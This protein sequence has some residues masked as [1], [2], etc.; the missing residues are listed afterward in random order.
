M[1]LEMNKESVIMKSVLRDREGFKD[2][3]YDRYLDADQLRQVLREADPTVDMDVDISEAAGL[4]QTETKTH[5][6][7]SAIDARVVTNDTKDGNNIGIGDND[8]DN[9]DDDESLS[10]G[11][12]NDGLLLAGDAAV[13]AD[14]DGAT[15]AGSQDGGDMGDLLYAHLLQVEA[16]SAYYLHPLDHHYHRHRHHH[17]PPHHHHHYNIIII[18]IISS[19][20]L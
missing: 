5:T 13:V 14:G 12:S 6:E 2:R 8:D 9:D 18:T 10:F 1:H 19:S 11:L 20:S 7:P 16:G 17:L 15:T 4:M 3:S